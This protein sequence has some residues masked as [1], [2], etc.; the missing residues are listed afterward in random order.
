ML[1][2]QQIASRMPDVPQA[3]LYRH[4]NKLAEGGI[5]R[6][7]ERRPVRGVEE[8]FYSLVENSTRFSREEFAA[9]APEEHERYFA[10]LMSTLSGALSRYVHQEDYDTTRDGMT[11]FQAAFHATDEQARQLR[12]D[13]LE[14]TKRYGGEGDQPGGRK[15]VLGVAL[16]P[17]AVSSRVRE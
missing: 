13:L 16:I 10:V 9:I 7:V 4:I 5:L 2:P 6:V 15:R 12:V 8:R 14:L 11:Y 3:T 1:S 17:V